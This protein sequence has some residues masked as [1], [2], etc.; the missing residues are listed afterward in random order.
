M[1]NKVSPSANFKVTL[2]R[3]PQLSFAPREQCALPL[4]V[5]VRRKFNVKVEEARRCTAIRQLAIVSSLPHQKV[6][7]HLRKGRALGDESVSPRFNLFCRKLP[8]GIGLGISHAQMNKSNP[9]EMEYP[10]KV[11]LFFF[12][13]PAGGGCLFS[14]LLPLV[15]GEFRGAG[16]PAGFPAGRAPRRGRCYIFLFAC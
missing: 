5:I 16:F 10:T 15:G 6:S 9:T 13:G 14:Y 12:V 4:A 7:P 11:V 1:G 2:P 8:S 3:N